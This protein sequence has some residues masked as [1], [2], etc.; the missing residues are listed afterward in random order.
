MK[1]KA[2]EGEIK[3]L[4]SS[5]PSD[6]QGVCSDCGAVYVHDKRDVLA[7]SWCTCPEVSGLEIFF[8]SNNGDHG[9]LHAVCGQVTQ[10]G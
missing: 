7:T 10:T 9:W 8:F 4:S 6:Q 1:C 2:C 5:I 3:R